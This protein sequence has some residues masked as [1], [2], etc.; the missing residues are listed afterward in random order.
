[1]CIRDRTYTNGLE[2]NCLLS[3]SATSTL[4]TIPG[5]CGGNVTE[6]WTAT[7]CGQTITRTRTI[8]VSP[9]TTPE[10]AAAGTITVAC[11]GATTHS[12][13]YTNGLSGN[14]LLSGSAT[15]T[16]G[17]IP[18]ACGGSVTESWTATVCGQ[19]ITRT[20]TIVVSPATTPTFAAANTITVACG[21]ATTHS[22][23]Y[24]NGLEGNCLLSGS[25]TSTLGTIPG[26]CGG[27]VTESWTATVCGQ[28]I[29][30]TR[31]IVVS[32]ATTP[33][34]AAA[35]TITVACGG[36][37]THSLAYTDGLE[38]YCLLSGTATSTL[39]TIPGA[40]GGN[41]TES[42]TATVCG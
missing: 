14:C 8:V 31:T 6:S 33:T 5:A 39:G 12:L 25:A 18:G 13:N 32:P 3:G 41:V 7:V 38:G 4:G 15:S 16:L 29:T 30:R 10:F 42:W 2:G 20:R 19:T 37:T 11:G 40:C 34:F 26:A 21:G 27:N 23:T 22:L 17:T 1:M 36:A 24:T 35:N 28:T 9:A